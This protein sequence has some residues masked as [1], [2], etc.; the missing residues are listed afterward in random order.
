ME[1]GELCLS[2]VGLSV[3]T[4]LSPAR[5]VGVMMGVFF[6]SNALGNKIAGFAAGFVGSMPLPSLFG[7]VAA[8]T[9][10]AAV[11][12]AVLVPGIRKLMAGVQ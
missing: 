5:L 2:P 1:I 3:V 8:V 6:L 7:T 10:G 11:V 12:L 9:L 4:K